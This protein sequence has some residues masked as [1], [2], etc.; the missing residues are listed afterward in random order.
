MI[1]EIITDPEKLAVP[2]KEV[3]DGEF[4]GDVIQDLLDTANNN[5]DKA[6]GLAANQIGYNQRIFIVKI[7]GKFIPIIN[8]EIIKRF[9]GLVVSREGCLSVPGKVVR[10]K[11]YKRIRLEFNDYRD[12]RRIQF[13]FKGFTAFVIQHE[14]DHLDGKTI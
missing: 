6:A 14:L 9:G 2:C 11:R 12:A 5:Y 1:R 13:N 4:I 10:V 3:E 7:S 8:P